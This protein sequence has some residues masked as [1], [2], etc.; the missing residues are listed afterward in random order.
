M[1]RSIHILYNIDPPAA[2]G[3]IHAASVQFVRKISGYSKPSKINELAFTTAVGEIEAIC[4]RLLAALETNAPA[5]ERSLG[6]S[7]R[8]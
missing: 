1:C 4:T 5:K 2:Q 7:S 6:V 8:S 3:E